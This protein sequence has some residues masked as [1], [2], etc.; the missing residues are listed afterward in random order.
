M[1][2]FKIIGDSC[3]DLTDD[4]K[5]E[6]NVSIVPLTINVDEKIFIDNDSLNTLELLKD[7]KKSS[8]IPKT[9]CPSPNDYIKEFEREKANFVVTLSSELSGSYNSAV[10]AK[11]LFLEEHPDQ[12]IYVFDSKS[13]ST[14]QG[15]IAMK[16]YELIQQGFEKEQVVEKVEQYITEMQTY[17]ILDSLDNLIKAGRIGVLSGK[18][19]TMLSIVPIMKSNDKGEIELL[20][21]VRGSKKAFKRL[22]DVI[23]EQGVK[24]EEKVLAIAHCNCKEKA[25]SFKDEAKKKYN[26]KDIVIFETHGISTVYA[27]DGGLI[28]SF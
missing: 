16:I 26:F 23:G 9:S 5:K 19:A 8:N 6:M 22:V 21:K 18:L 2:Q 1:M 27:N 4:L 13:A 25:I 11:D 3:C 14:G 28:I 17:F 10:L 15:L 7:M 12:F 24:L 20:E